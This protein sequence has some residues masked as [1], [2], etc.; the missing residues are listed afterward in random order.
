MKGCPFLTKVRG[1]GTILDQNI[2][3]LGIMSIGNFLEFSEDSRLTM[4]DETTFSSFFMMA[5]H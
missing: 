5:L 4:Y 2:M 3:R 1:Q